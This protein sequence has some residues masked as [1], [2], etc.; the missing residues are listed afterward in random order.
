M[1]N[2]QLSVTLERGSSEIVKP[3]NTRPWLRGQRW[4]YGDRTPTHVTQA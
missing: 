2:E 1:G 4:L 3:G